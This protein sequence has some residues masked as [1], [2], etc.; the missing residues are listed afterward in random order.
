MEQRIGALFADGVGRITAFLPDLVAAI[1]ILALGYIVSRVLSAVA[2]AVL[3]RGHFDRFVAQR[4]HAGMAEQAS[5][6][7]TVGAAT[8]WIGMLVTFSLVSRALHLYALSDGINRIIGYLPR[9][10]VAT[11]VVAIGIGVG[12]MVTRLLTGTVHPTLVKAARAAIVVFASFMALDELGVAH[13]V[14]MTAFVLAL[15]AAAAAAAISFGVGNRRVAEELTRR[16][17]KRAEDLNRPEPPEVP[18][19]H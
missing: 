19:A 8:F 13:G 3:T 9:L 11:V 7:A 14:V 5:P 10:F 2:R 16:W 15:G 1:V 17:L 6:T 4:I 12:R 18:L